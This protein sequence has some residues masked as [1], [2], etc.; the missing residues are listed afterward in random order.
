MRGAD[1]AR[2]EPLLMAILAQL[3]SSL[4]L[5]YSLPGMPGVTQAELLS[6][7]ATL[8]DFFLHGGVLEPGAVAATV[9]PL[10]E[11]LTERDAMLAAVGEPEGAGP[12]A[13]RVK[14][15]IAKP[16]KIGAM[17]SSIL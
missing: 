6:D 3:V 17:F 8:R 4:G 14:G 11:L 16:K 9:Q 13:Q 7:A 12:I 15:F 5:L 10:V 1:E 2:R